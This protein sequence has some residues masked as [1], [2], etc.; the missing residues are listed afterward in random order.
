MTCAK[1]GLIL[2]H[3][4]DVSAEWG[5]ICARALKPSAVSD[6]THIY[7]GRDTPKATGTTGA[8]IDPDIKGDIGVHSFWKSSHLT[9]FDV[10]IT[11]TDAKLYRSTDPHKVLKQQ[12]RE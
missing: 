12:E 11:D 9:I 10:R 7:T 4:N 5:E 1:G 6:E 8:K 3:H 2:Y